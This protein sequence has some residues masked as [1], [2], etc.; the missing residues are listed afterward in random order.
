MDEKYSEFGCVRFH[1]SVFSRLATDAGNYGC[2]ATD[3]TILDN[4]FAAASQT[5]EAYLQSVMDN[6]EGKVS[7]EF[8]VLSRQLAQLTMLHALYVSAGRQVFQF[9]PSIL[10]DFKRTD[11]SETPIGKLTLPYSAG[12]LHFGRQND[13]L[14]DDQWRTEA[15]YV[16]GAYYHCGPEGQL[17]IQFTLSRPGGNWSRLPGPSF[18]IPKADLGMPAHEVI[19][20]AL[21]SD[22][23]DAEDH[24]FKEAI[25]QTVQEWDAVTRP[26]VHAALSLV[27]NALFYL[28]G[29]GADSEPIV[30]S[31]APQA[32]RESYERAIKGGKP[33]AIRNARNALMAEGF[34]VV[35]LCGVRSDS[36][37]ASDER[38]NGGMSVRTHWRRGHWRIQPCGPKLSQI[39]RIW[40]RP[41]LVGKAAGSVVKGHVYSVEESHQGG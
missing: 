30:P 23:A 6:F 8:Y 16:D 31:E 25:H 41:T 14:L 10:A 36:A 17:T 39:K 34:T 27:L 33:K 24:R 2:M 22:I 18:S 32:V 38:G 29:Y 13:L 1:N 12:F 20:K 21:D 3:G 28:D 40:V 35:R 7:A 4:A 26:I 19:D 11:L 5:T 9:T 15:E 37:E